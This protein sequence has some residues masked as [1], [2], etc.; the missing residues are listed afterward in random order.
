MVGGWRI[1]ISAYAGM[2]WGRWG[3]SGRHGGLRSVCTLRLPLICP[4][5]GYTKVS[6]SGNPYK[7]GPKRHSRPH[8]VIPANAG[9]LRGPCPTMYPS[10]LPRAE[11]PFPTP[12]RHSHESGNPATRRQPSATEGRRTPIAQYL[13]TMSRLRPSSPQAR[14]RP[15]SPRPLALPRPPRPLPFLPR[16][17]PCPSGGGRHRLRELPDGAANRWRE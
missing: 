16:P 9:T 2:T 7:R 6:E 15:C 5:K 14:V 4:S 3:C 8:H 17:S 13:P 10:L 12:S 1:Q 11:T